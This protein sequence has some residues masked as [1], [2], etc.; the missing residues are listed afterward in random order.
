MQ[1]AIQDFLFSPLYLVLNFSLSVL[2]VFIKDLFKYGNFHVW[3]LV[4]WQVE[5]F[6]RGLV[7]VWFSYIP[8]WSY[9]FS[10]NEST[11]GMVFRCIF[12]YPMSL[13]HIGKQRIKKILS[14]P[15]CPWCYWISNFFTQ[16]VFAWMSS[17]RPFQQRKKT[18]VRKQ[19][20][21]RKYIIFYK[22]SHKNITQKLY[23]YFLK[24]KT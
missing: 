21:D 17:S 11:R 24:I 1:L 7:C 22:K 13:N 9:Y 18:T 16:G 15:C 14:I 12:R 6:S 3:Y 2:R 19:K 20:V 5:V 10:S 23:K 8:L 4:S